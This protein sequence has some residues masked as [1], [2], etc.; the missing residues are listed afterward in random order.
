MS[1]HPI[2]QISFLFFFVFVFGS[3]H[4]F[5]TG[6]MITFFFC[7]R[8]QGRN[9][10]VCVCVWER[11]LSPPFSPNFLNI[12]AGIDHPPF[13]PTPVGRQTSVSLGLCHKYY[14]PDYTYQVYIKVIASFTYIFLFA[15][16][17]SRSPRA[18]VFKSRRL[19]DRKYAIP[20]VSL[21]ISSSRPERHARAYF[22]RVRGEKYGGRKCLFANVLHTP[23]SPLFFLTMS[24]LFY[25]LNMELFFMEHL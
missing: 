13:P 2:P 6:L 9:S 20:G 23:P 3:V 7:S 24:S 21:N 16:P 19:P 15:V 11:N 5:L 12:S 17:V 10:C 14:T 4:F 8:N 25:Y 18:K 22:W 1:P